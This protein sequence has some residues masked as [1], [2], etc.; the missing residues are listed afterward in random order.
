MY[1][2]V[3]KVVTPQDLPGISP[4]CCFVALTAHTA[5]CAHVRKN[6]LKSQLPL[7]P[8]WLC[9]LSSLMFCNIILIWERTNLDICVSTEVD[10]YK[11]KTKT[12]QSLGQHPRI[13]KEL[14]IIS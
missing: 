2:K 14:P 1:F 5:S 10:L 6:I 11:G 8:L 12:L 9:V 4:C 13:K 3:R 7:H